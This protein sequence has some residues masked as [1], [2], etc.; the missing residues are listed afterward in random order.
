[1]LATCHVR[2]HHLRKIYTVYINWLALWAYCTVPV[3]YCTVVA[4]EPSYNPPKTR[5]FSALASSAFLPE[6]LFSSPTPYR[7]SSH[8]IEPRVSPHSVPAPLSTPTSPTAL[9]LFCFRNPT[10]NP[11]LRP[12]RRT[13]T[14]PDP[15]QHSAAPPP[16]RWTALQARTLARFC[17]K[18][19]AA[20]ALTSTSFR[21]Q[22]PLRPPAAR[23]LSAVVARHPPRRQTHL[24]C[25]RWKRSITRSLPR[26][27]QA[28]Q[29]PDRV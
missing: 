22:G 7:S 26:P 16:S 20:T 12:T 14:H 23:E 13:P 1:M 24:P 27:R 4:P 6:K 29:D 15:P 21:H 18:E 2:H 5:S 8:M 19:T 17:A 10:A 9:A 25:S 3:L 28:P 11:Q